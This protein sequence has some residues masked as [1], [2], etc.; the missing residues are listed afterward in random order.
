MENTMAN[1]MTVFKTPAGIGAMDIRVVQIDGN[2]WFVAADVCRALGRGNPTMALKLLGSDEKA[3][4]R[5]EGLSRFGSINCV[6]ESGLYKLMM[7]SDKPEARVFQDW[8]TRDVLP[9]LRKHGTYVVGQE[10]VASG[11]MTLA[12]FARVAADAYKRLSE[13]LQVEVDKLTSENAVMSDELNLVTVDEWRALKH[14]Y[15]SHSD[16]VRLSQ[17]ASME[18]RVSGVTLEKQRRT[19]TASA[20][21]RKVTV[22]IYPRPILDN[23]AT[24]LGIL[25]RA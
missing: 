17:W 6:S 10:K 1:D 22:N 5:N 23:A 18:A 11:E 21:Y 13:A 7:R 8:V 25:P 24:A 20:G 14:I 19:L 3:L 9:S 2:P 4:I 16:K 15:L 12:D